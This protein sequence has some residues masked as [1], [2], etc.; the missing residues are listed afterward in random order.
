MRK[1][2][3]NKRVINQ[4]GLA[5]TIETEVLPIQAVD[6]AGLFF[7]WSN[8]AGLAATFTIQVS[9]DNETWY[10][11]PFG[12]AIALSG[13]SGSNF[14]QLNDH[15]FKSMK[16]V[17]TFTGGSCDLVCWYGATTKGA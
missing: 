16:G 9:F 13:A 12:S 10:D 1:H 5:V 6:L 11:L 2:F 8:G 7:S 17:F 15:F 3:I 14:A 4:T